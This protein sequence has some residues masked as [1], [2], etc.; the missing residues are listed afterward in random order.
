MENGTTLFTLPTHELE[1]SSLFR[2][3]PLA[4]YHA[5]VFMSQTPAKLGQGLDA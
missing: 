1:S 5:A 4:R 3:K 2:D